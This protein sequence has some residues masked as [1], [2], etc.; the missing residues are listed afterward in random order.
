MTPQQDDGGLVFNPG[1]NVLSVATVDASLYRIGGHSVAPLRAW[2]NADTTGTVSIRDDLKV[3]SL[4]DQ[5][6]GYNQ[7]NFS[8]TFTDNDYCQVATTGV[9]PGYGNS[10]AINAWEELSGAGQDQTKTTTTCQLNT[11][12]ANNGYADTG[13]LQAM[14]AR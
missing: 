3:S 4:T 6:T 13:E 9:T 10:Y 2:V 5:G 8:L 1:T 12:A 14:Y 11:S 7:I